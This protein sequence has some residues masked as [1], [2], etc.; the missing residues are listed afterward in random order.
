MVQ[1]Q[2]QVFTQVMPT[3]VELLPSVVLVERTAPVLASAQECLASAQNTLN[4]LSSC[5]QQVASAAALAQRQAEMLARL[6]A[7]GLVPR[8]SIGQQASVFHFAPAE[9]SVLTKPG[10]LRAVFH[11]SVS[12]FR[13]LVDSL[14][15]A[16]DFR[17][18][19]NWH[20]AAEASKIFPMM[21]VRRRVSSIVRC[22]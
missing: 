20:T 19:T 7:S 12:A 16:V 11:L 15:G 5:I 9:V 10:A 3:P 21:N 1:T 18:V 13:H 17:G 4:N 22:S 6:Q 14:R 8:A 2:S